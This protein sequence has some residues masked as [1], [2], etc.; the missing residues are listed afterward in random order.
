MLIHQHAA[1]SKSAMLQWISLHFATTVQY[2]FKFLAYTAV[3]KRWCFL[4]KQKTSSD[5][6]RDKQVP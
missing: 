4:I 2:V 3:S 6:G 1:L 5:F